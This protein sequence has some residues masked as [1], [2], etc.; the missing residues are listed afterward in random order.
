MEHSPGGRSLAS[1]SDSCTARI[2]NLNAGVVEKPDL[3]QARIERKD[4]NCRG[5]DL[6][7]SATH[8][9]FAN[10]QTIS[11]YS[12]SLLRSRHRP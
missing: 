5:R 6:A 9:L 7:R 1:K 2:K 10:A 11:G 3:A 12:S 4:L 8:A